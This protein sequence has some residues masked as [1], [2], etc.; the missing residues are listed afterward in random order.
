[1]GFNPDSLAQLPHVLSIYYCYR[2]KETPITDPGVVLVSP[3][4]VKG[5]ASV[6][7]NGKRSQYRKLT[8][9]KSAVSV[10]R[11]ARLLRGKK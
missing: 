2:S 3:P 10:R 9:E 11:S 4:S 1:M 6:S 8:S 5:G 7:G